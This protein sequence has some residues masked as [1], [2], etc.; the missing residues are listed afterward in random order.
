MA[1]LK[2]QSLVLAEEE[3]EATLQLQR[4]HLSFRT[5]T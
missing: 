4:K 5:R 2:Q 1:M 3:A